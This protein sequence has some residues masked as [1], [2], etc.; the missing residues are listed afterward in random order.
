MPSDSM[1]K[2]LMSSESQVYSDKLRSCKLTNEEINN[3]LQGCGASKLSN[4]FLEQCDGSLKKALT[5]GDKAQDYETV[6]KI[7]NT[8]DKVDIAKVWNS[9]DL[10]YKS[11]D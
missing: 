8:L 7:I 10:L 4:T 9:A 11:Q 2:R 3:Y 1:M 5:I 6:E